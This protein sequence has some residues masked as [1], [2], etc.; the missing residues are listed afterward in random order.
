MRKTELKI[1]IK[2]LAAEAAIIKAEEEKLLRRSRKMKQPLGPLF[3]NL[4]G[5][6][7]HV[8]GREARHSLLAYAI[9]R[10]V[11]YG[12]VESY[13]EAA[14]EWYDVKKLA[15]RFGPLSALG[16]ID[17]D[18]AA[19]TDVWLEEAKAYFAHAETASAIAA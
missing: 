16:V 19:R 4:R 5:H 13:S 8:V 10:A 6:R 3:F 18:F 12:Q 9:L 17:A 14:P 7:K 11:A 15:L 2:S 1:K